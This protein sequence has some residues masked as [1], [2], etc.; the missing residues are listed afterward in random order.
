MTAERPLFDRPGWRVFILRSVL[1]DHPERADLTARL[2]ELVRL[3][4]MAPASRAAR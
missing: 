1:R 3:D 2:D 4:Q